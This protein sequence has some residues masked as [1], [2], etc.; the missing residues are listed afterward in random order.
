MKKS[1]VEI[2]FI[3]LLLFSVLFVSENY[4]HYNN[5]Y[6]DSAIENN[7][8]VEA[9]AAT[10]FGKMYSIGSGVKINSWGLIVTA[11]HCVEGASYIKITGK[12][13]SCYT[14][15]WYMDEYHDLAILVVPKYFYEYASIGC[16]ND[17]IKGEDVFAIGNPAGIWDNS[18]LKGRI[19]DDHFERLAL[20]ENGYYIFLKA[21]AMPGYS[22]GGVYYKDKLIGILVSGTK[23]ATFV[24]PVE[25][26]KNLIEKYNAR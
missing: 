13:F 19:Y 6:I 24:V 21:D 26:V 9:V 22:G 17:V 14:S 20:S 25:Y 5:Q 8:V 12:D 2:L 10:P 15:I 3:G 23:G 16:L 18:V 1:S 7:V 11:K 4:K